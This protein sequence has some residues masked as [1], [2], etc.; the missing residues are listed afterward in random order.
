MDKSSRRCFLEVYVDGFEEPRLMQ[1][2]PS[3][4]FH[5]VLDRFDAA[6][7]LY[8]GEQR[9]DP[10][11]TPV[12]LRMPCGV[13]AANELWFVPAAP[14][15]PLP[16]PQRGTS[17]LPAHF[18]NTTAST[19]PPPE[20]PL[21]LRRQPAGVVGAPGAVDAPPASWYS[22]PRLLSPALPQS[23][24][25]GS[26][27]RP[28]TAALPQTTAAATVLP[29]S[30]L[31]GTPNGSVDASVVAHH[32]VAPPRHHHYAAAPPN[33]T[34]PV[35][36]PA[37]PTRRNAPILMDPSLLIDEAA[38]VALGAELQRLRSEL[39]SLRGR[40]TAPLRRQ[41]FVRVPDAGIVHAVA[42]LSQSPSPIR[43]AAGVEELA[44]DLHDRQ[45]HRLYEQRR[46]YLTHDAR[47]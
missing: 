16:H 20:Q 30:I 45:M 19:P 38:D 9:V 47:A 22:R 27:D 42:H 33:V 17:S 36:P 43:A 6:G 26:I 37:P 25:L 18:E 44:L 10:E 24:R 23:A 1:L 40:D 3:V 14:S 8:W 41:V 7:D 29:P 46:L 35:P 32:A 5:N 11:A 31:K 2:E 39:E 28:P 34:A 13:E 12:A 15:P 4:K 21:Q